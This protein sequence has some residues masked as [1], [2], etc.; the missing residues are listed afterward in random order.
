MPWVTVKSTVILQ[1]VNGRSENLQFLQWKGLQCKL[2]SFDG[3][4]HTVAKYFRAKR[5]G[6]EIVSNW[7]LKDIFR[8]ITDT[9]DEETTKENEGND[10]V[11]KQI[12][13]DKV[14]FILNALDA[15]KELCDLSDDPFDFEEEDQ[16]QIFLFFSPSPS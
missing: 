4:R 10:R 12:S 15:D 7:I 8:I 1:W 3:P 11:S 13:C 14:K 16:I 6:A 9:I 2:F 5:F